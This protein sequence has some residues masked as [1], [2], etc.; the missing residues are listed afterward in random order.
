ML[1]T[2]PI[3]FSDKLT[4]CGSK[5]HPRKGWISSIACHW[6][7]SWNR[8]VPNRWR[9]AS[10]TYTAIKR[11]SPSN[12]RC[13]S[14]IWL[15]KFPALRLQFVLEVFV[16]L[17][18]K[19]NRFLRFAVVKPP[20]TLR[21]FLRNLWTQCAVHSSGCSLRNILVTML[22]RLTTVKRS[23]KSRVVLSKAW[24]NNTRM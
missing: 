18:C 6:W 8:S 3:H 9:C 12:G 1:G 16:T 4:S 10:Y 14:S 15:D 24:V 2:H 22:E 11:N 13:F 17:P 20:L 23:R 19:T 5:Y 21:N 7:L